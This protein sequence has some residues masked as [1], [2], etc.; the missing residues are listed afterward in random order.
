M[1][2]DLFA[3]LHKY[4]IVLK[5]S[6]CVHDIP[7]KTVPEKTVP[8]KKT[9]RV[10]N[11]TPINA[12]ESN[13]IFSEL[14]NINLEGKKTKSQYTKP[15]VTHLPTESN[16][17]IENVASCVMPPMKVVMDGDKIRWNGAYIYI[18]CEHDHI[19]QYLNINVMQNNPICITCNQPGKMVNNARLRAEELLS[20]P[21][22][23]ESRN[24]NYSE[25]RSQKHNIFL[26]IVKKGFDI[27]K[28]DFRYVAVSET[29]S[30][31][32]ID[33]QIKRQC[34][35][36]IEINKPIKPVQANKLPYP[37]EFAAQKYPNIIR[38]DHLYI[39]NC[40]YE[41]IIQ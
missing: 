17:S 30:I 16:F 35:D 18:S 40:G 11:S 27:G 14:A 4:D 25:Y 8:E 24:K 26:Y 20:T 33:D 41:S 28:K 34:S 1:N 10:K 38:D 22:I 19:H 32:V 3:D 23:F 7:E 2:D 39:E 15:N 31:K 13:D 36:I 6:R 29:R 37:I 9:V 12:I 5:Q 21:F